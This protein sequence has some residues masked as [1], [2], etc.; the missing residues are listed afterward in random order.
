MP[1]LPLTLLTLALAALLAA[2]SARSA[3]PDPEP[4]KTTLKEIL[5]AHPKDEKAVEELFKMTLGRKPSAEEAK[6]VLASVQAK[7]KGARAKAYEDVHWALTNSKE[8][9]ARQKDKA[10]APKPK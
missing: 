10:K 3:D 6:V 8:Y 9:Q 1:R 4:P 2:P 7:G 5:K